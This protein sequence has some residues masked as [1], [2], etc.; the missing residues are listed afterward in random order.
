M[1]EKKSLL[2]ES[3]LRDLLEKSSLKFWEDE[4]IDSATE[5][6]QSIWAFGDEMSSLF[7]VECKTNNLTNGCAEGCAYCCHQNIQISI[8]EAVGI[9]KWIKSNF[10]DVK[11]SEILKRAEAICKSGVEDE[12]DSQRWSRREAC[13]CLDIHTNKCM[14]YPVRPIECRTTLIY[15]KTSCKNSYE[16]TNS[17]GIS[18]SDKEVIHVAL[19][20]TESVE[21]NSVS[22]Y[23]LSCL[24]DVNLMKWFQK[25]YK[26]DEMTGS[27]VED[28]HKIM[29]PF[30]FELS[31]V[32]KNGL[33]SNSD[34]VIDSLVNFDSNALYS[35]QKQTDSDL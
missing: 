3:E 20:K 13:P 17:S 35:C 10:N 7:K 24:F 6:A 23:I 22:E 30:D 27:V 19:P 8:F 34:A 31:K 29:A 18:V 16:D 5:V 32:L 25:L 2:L 9:L 1:S 21:V 4:S 11:K 14:I 28:A 33:K 12:G 26:N 15:D